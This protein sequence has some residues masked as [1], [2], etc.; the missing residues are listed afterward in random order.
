MLVRGAN[1]L[2]FCL[3]DGTMPDDQVMDLIET[4]PEDI[5]RA[6]DP[7]AVLS[8]GSFH[9][10]LVVRSEFRFGYQTGPRGLN[11]SMRNKK[12]PHNSFES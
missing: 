12:T 3:G 8:A 4:T 1:E 11:K 10:V 9:R 2:R 5:G 7:R 6:K